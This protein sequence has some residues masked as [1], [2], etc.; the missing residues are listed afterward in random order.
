MKESAQKFRSVSISRSMV[1]FTTPYE[2][3]PT[4]IFNSPPTTQPDTI[5]VF[6]LRCSDQPLCP[7]LADLHLGRGGIPSGQNVVAYKNFGN[8][9]VIEF[10]SAGFFTQSCAPASLKFEAILYSN[11]R[12]KF[13]VQ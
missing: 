10:D 2:W 6:L 13:P 3:E 8:Y 5:V 1:F 12:I 9:F 7:N 11:G 4:A